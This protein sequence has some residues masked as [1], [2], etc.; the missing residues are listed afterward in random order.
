[1]CSCGGQ[2]FRWTAS[3]R[4]RAGGLAGF[5]RT[6]R[7]N[8]FKIGLAET[9][10]CARDPRRSVGG[11]AI[12]AEAGVALAVLRD[13]FGLGAFRRDF[14]CLLAGP[15]H[16]SGA[17]ACGHRRCK[18]TRRPGISRMWDREQERRAFPIMS[19]GA[20]GGDS[21]RRRPRQTRRRF[22]LRKPGQHRLART[23]STP[24]ISRR[25]MRWPRGLRASCARGWFAASACAGAD[26]ASICAAPFTATFRMAARR[27][28]SPGAG[29]RSN[30]CGSSSCST[31]PA[32]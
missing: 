29:A 1:M 10:R 27:W 30:R 16:P 3:V 24:P 28:N 6:L 4:R 31:P 21:R 5:A 19:S 32:P 12:H 14:R 7:D 15:R 9:A 17:H 20:D 22:A 26:A 2:H 8:G 11:A 18:A 23:S 25:R 13:A